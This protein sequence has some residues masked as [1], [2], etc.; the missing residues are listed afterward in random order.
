MRLG[1]LSSGL[2]TDTMV[3]E[4]MKPYQSKV[5]K[6]K[7]DKLLVEY[8]QEIYRDIMKDMRG[9]Y[10]KYL[11][12]GSSAN[13]DTN[14]LLS[15]NYET[16]AFTSSNDSVVTARGLAG[17]KGG[18]YSVTVKQM[19]S[20]SKLSI[21][22][23]AFKGATGDSVEIKVGGE[24]INVS[25]L[26]KEGNSITENSRA[27]VDNINT[28]IAEHNKKDGVNKIDI[29]VSYSEMGNNITLEGKN[30]GEGNNL[31]MS[32]S[33]VA[34]KNDKGEDTF[35][36]IEAK[37][38]IVD[39]KDSSGN[40]VRDKKY[41]SNKFIIDNVEYSIN[42]VSEEIKDSI[43]ATIG[44]EETKLNGKADTKKTVENIRNFVNDYNNMID[45][46]NKLLVEKSDSS[47]R[48]LTEEQKKEMSE[49]E[50]KLWNAKVK[51]GLLRSDDI[52]S[53]TINEF[54]GHLSTKMGSG[55]NLSAIGI[56]TNPDYRTQKGKIILDEDKLSKALSE[57]GEETRKLLNDTFGKIK[58]TLNNTAVSSGSKL[59]KKAGYEGTATAINNELTKKMETQQ[60]RIDQLAKALKSK[61]DAYYKQFTRLEVAM[62]KA[63]SQM[64][65]FMQQ[66][67]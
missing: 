20:A 2:D 64:S 40:I 57:N 12:I 48:P 11:D 53:G 39:L 52:L 21:N 7:Q 51:K 54:L 22:M 17:A 32:I 43:G 36:F 63:N 58:D 61:E 55:L 5:D 38:A 13:K 29:K 66:M 31:E 19:A 28:A 1:G 33:G 47:Y 67:G 27:I 50:I 15:S 42:G 14:L 41:S 25:L 8:K 6:A 16:V 23:D 45:K 26:D 37:D 60:K 59:A 44:Y 34:N 9:I 56:S 18:N 30:T 46:V 10:T 24:T 49:D 3:K 4:M 62:N 35:K 65:Y